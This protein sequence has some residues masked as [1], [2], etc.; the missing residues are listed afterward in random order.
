M[1]YKQKVGKFGEILAKQYLIKKGYKIIDTNVQV[2]HKELDIIAKIKEK[3][4]FIEVRTRASENMGSADDNF[5]QKKL[6]LLKKALNGYVLMHSLDPENVRLD[7]LCIDIR[8][9]EKTAKIKH[10]KDIF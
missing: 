9:P 8:K 2:R 4:I 1:N 7:L 5:S 6:N 10:Y 3:Y